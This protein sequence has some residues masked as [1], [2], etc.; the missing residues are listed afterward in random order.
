MTGTIPLR[1]TWLGT[2]SIYERNMNVI[3]I[4]YYY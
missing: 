2:A 3:H 1:S 4:A